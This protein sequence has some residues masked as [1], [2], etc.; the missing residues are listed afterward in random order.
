MRTAGPRAAFRDALS[1]RML[2]ECGAVY[3]SESFLFFKTFHR[4]DFSGFTQLTSATSVPSALP[5][6]FQ[7]QQLLCCQV[8]GLLSGGGA[9]LDPRSSSPG[10][11]AQSIDRSVTSTTFW[12]EGGA[13]KGGEVNKA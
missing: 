1:S 10:P 6:S 3:I 5:A 9:I 8:P 13:R 7:N 2:P 4:V 12:R 11:A